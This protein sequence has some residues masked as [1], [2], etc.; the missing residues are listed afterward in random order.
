MI[1][2]GEERQVLVGLGEVLWDMLPTGKQLGGAPANFAYHAQALGGRGVVVSC[3]GEDVLGQEILTRLDQ[4]GFEHRYVAIDRDHPT[5][6]VSVELDAEGKPTYTIHENVAWDYLPYSS[7]LEALAGDTDAVCF[8]SLGQRSQVSRETIG[9][10]LEATKPDCLRLFD[11]NLR[12]SYFNK[13]IIHSLLQLS[14]VLKL[15]EPE[16]QVLTQLLAISGSETEVLRQLSERYALRVI[17][18][19]RGERGSRLVTPDEES[20]HPGFEVE[21]ADTVGAGDSF[22]AVLAI[23]LLRGWKL[24]QINERANH[25]ASFVCSQNG[26]TPVLPSDLVKIA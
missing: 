5:G 26:A 7:D 8:G 16:L 11:L 1:G 15:N 20:Q 2:P 4:L 12:Q 3:V 9:Q 21:V 14:N 22:A 13:E 24:D 23:G 17:A 25:I 19:T 10:F 6:T 18:L